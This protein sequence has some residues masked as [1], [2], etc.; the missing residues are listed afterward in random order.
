M[1]YIYLEISE[2]QSTSVARFIEILLK[3]PN[4]VINS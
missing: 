2:L 1:K 4:N 3:I